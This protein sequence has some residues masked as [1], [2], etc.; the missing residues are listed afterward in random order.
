AA[1]FKEMR[2]VCMHT[3]YPFS[4]KVHVKMDTG[5]GRLGI[6]E[7]LEWEEMLPWLRA[8]DI[9]VDG[10]FTH[11]ATAGGT[12]TG[13]L[14]T[15]FDRFREMIAWV[16]SSQVHVNV[17]HCA[18][19]A[20]ALRFPEMAMDMVRIGAAMYGF[21]PR[22]A[23]GAVKLD[24]ALSLYSSL[25]QV[26]RL[27]KGGYVGYDQAYRAGRDE[28]VGTVP[29]GYADGWSQSLRHSQM[30]IDGHRVPVIGKIGMDQ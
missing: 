9:I 16:A 1:W 21:G 20:A 25:I 13:Y 24:A 26:K 17:F 22:T 30:I 19:S 6:R 12:D 7:K 28:W 23:A 14:R 2:R 4:L 10:V 15:Q 18:N 29:I 3:F 27:K 11:F 5:L 8:S